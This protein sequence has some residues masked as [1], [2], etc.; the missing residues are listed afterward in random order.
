MGKGS[1]GGAAAVTLAS[2]P[3]QA[4]ATSCHNQ[5]VAYP[6]DLPTIIVFDLDDCLWTP[7]MHELSGLPSIPVE[8]PLDPTDNESELGTIG[9]KVPSRKRGR[10]KGFDWGGYNNS[11]EIVELYPGARLALRE[12]ATNP[13]YK[14]IIIAVASTSLEP[15]YSR[16]CIDG[17]E[18][19]E[20]VT[21]K[22]MISYA[23]IG[24][25]GK[26]TSRKTSH[27]QLIHEE[28]GFVPHEEMLFFDDCNWGDHVGDLNNEFGVIGVRTPQG[29][30]LEEFHHGLEKFRAGK[31]R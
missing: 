13:K 6:T 30:T 21:M 15:S 16:A 24:R 17:I 26:L 12:L 11:E 27:F 14:D 31:R 29:L 3:A 9:M 22:D 7:E 25:D 23:Q 1:S 4:A 2:S 5:E 8:G 20:G 18:I 19:V 10:G 28:S